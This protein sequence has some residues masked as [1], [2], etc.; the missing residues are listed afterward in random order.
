[1]AKQQMPDDQGRVSKVPP[2]EPHA[3]SVDRIRKDRKAQDRGR[4]AKLPTK[5]S[6]C[7]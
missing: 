6:K 2:V 4:V 3:G 1:M 7:K 5:G